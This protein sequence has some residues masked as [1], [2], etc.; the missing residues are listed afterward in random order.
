MPSKGKQS[1]LHGAMILFIANGI[2][3]VI[4]AIFKI[5]LT[6]LIGSAGMGY[7][8]TAY[9]IFNLVYSISIAGLPIAVSKMVSEN[10]AKGRYIDVRRIVKISTSLF[11][12]TGTV[13]TTVM[14]VFSGAFSQMVLNP[15]AYWS[16]IAIAPTVFFGCVMS[17]YRGYYQGMRN[18]YPTAISQV[19]ETV[20]KLIF[21]L[22]LAVMVINIGMDE[23]SKMGTVFGQIAE[24]AQNAKELTLPYAAAASI[25]GVTISTALGAFYL[26]IRHRRAGDGI[27]REQLENSPPPRDRKKLLKR[28]IWI[29][30]PVCLGA[31]VTNLTGMIDLGSIMN[32]LTSIIQSNPSDLKMAYTGL[33]YE[34]LKDM[35]A[36]DIPNYLYGVYQV[37]INLYNLIP[38]FIVTFGVSALPAI[39]SSWSLGDMHETKK[40]IDSVLRVSMMISVPAGLGLSVLAEPILKLL[41]G[42]IPEQMAIAAPL[43]STL[44]IAAVFASMLGPIISMLQG[45]GRTDIPAKILLIGGLLK[46]VLNYLL[47]GNPSVNIS[48][49]SVSTL[50]CYVFLFLIALISLIR[51][52]GVVPNLKAVFVKPI[53]AGAV[54]ALV[55]FYLQDALYRIMPSRL[56]VLLTVVIAIVADFIV[57]ILIR[58]VY[59]QDIRMIP[60]GK[61]LATFLKKNKLLS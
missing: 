11:L 60:G 25:L 50:V 47:I 34:G 45:V 43:L 54:C 10:V 37:A 22:F 27:T 4:G 26:I 18:M 6:N 23:Y 57:L 32:R 28:L 36:A 59:E 15:G 35:K 31:I 56:T 9:T 38:P 51:N 58:G 49:A 40:S 5:P 8:G 3:T 24:S 1:V 41:Y 52:T 17:I 55:A 2:V 48:G 12:I 14:I 19:V 61:K 30:V 42:S 53:L 33:A 13:G 16:F 44:G 20:G 7:F 39:S 29:A 46:L 21:G